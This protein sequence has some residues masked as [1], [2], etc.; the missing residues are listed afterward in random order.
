MFVQ[1]KIT[2]EEVKIERSELMS[3]AEAARELKMSQPGIYRAIE[4]GR[5]REIIDK[6]REGQHFRRLVVRSEV[7]LMKFDRI[8]RGVMEA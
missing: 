3:M 7:Q 2:Y 8:L 6:D 4:H 5:L 1:K